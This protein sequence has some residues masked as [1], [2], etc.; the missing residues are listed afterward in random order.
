LRIAGLPTRFIDA[1][2]LNLL[3]KIPDWHNQIPAN[4][5]LTPHPGELGTLR[6]QSI[7][8]I[9]ADRVKSALE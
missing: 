5:I 9:E 7:D 3:A 2:G 6:N 8:E 1:D 4:N